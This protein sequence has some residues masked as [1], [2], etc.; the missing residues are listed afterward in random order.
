[1]HP[2]E[3]VPAIRR[4]DTDRDDLLAVEIARPM[5]G[6][7][8]ENLY[9]LLEGAYALHDSIDVLV[10]WPEDEDV[11]WP[12]VDSDTVKE[13]RNHA[14]EHIRR[15]AAIGGSGEVSALMRTL[16]GESVEFRRFA[17]DEEAAAWDWLEAEPSARS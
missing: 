10:R 9:G 16:C 6:A 8:V 13:A 11:A 15:C 7:D 12:E 4:I 2:L 17:A 14:R 3:A 5:T 1:M